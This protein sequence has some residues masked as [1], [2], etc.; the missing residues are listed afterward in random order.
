M[1]FITIHMFSV[2]WILVY[3]GG[4]RKAKSVYRVSDEILPMNAIQLNLLGMY[5]VRVACIE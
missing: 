5:S 3:I 1:K 2:E 4:L